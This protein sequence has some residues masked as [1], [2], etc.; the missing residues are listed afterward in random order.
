MKRVKQL[1]FWCILASGPWREARAQ[2]VGQAE[3]YRVPAPG[4]AGRFQVP[5]VRLQ[6][7]AVARLINRQLLRGVLGEEE[8]N[9]KATPQRQLYLAARKCC[10]DADTRTWAAAGGGLTGSWYSVLLNRAGLLSLSLTR[11]YTGAHHTFD[12]Q[13]FTFDLRTGHR[14]ALAD[15]VADPAPQLV[16]RMQGAINRRYA[17]A[18]AIA[19]EARTDSATIAEMTEVFHWDW[20][21]RRVRWFVGDTSAAVLALTAADPD[22]ET[23][24]LT[25]A[26]LLLFHNAGFHRL[27]QAP[28]PDN[29][30]RFPY[31]RLHVKPLLQPLVPLA[32]AAAVKK[33]KS[34]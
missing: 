25:S 4:E 9:A 12:T 23:F 16:R 7:A 5:Q 29:T 27:S 15:V 10:Y 14:L 24:A 11:Q 33:P 31:T 13:F 22:V 28:Q 6:D 18:L 19:A 21:A 1:A 34:K 8:V 20:N 2:A 26:A 3:I 32:K 30:Y 17:E